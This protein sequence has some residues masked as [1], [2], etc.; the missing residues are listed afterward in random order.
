MAEKPQRLVQF[1]GMDWEKEE[2]KSIRG[3][4]ARKKANFSSLRAA[5]RERTKIAATQRR[6]KVIAFANY[7]CGDIIE[8]DLREEIVAIPLL[9]SLDCICKHVAMKHPMD[10]NPIVPDSLVER[11]R[12]LC[13]VLD[14]VPATNSAFCLFEAWMRHSLRRGIFKHDLVSRTSIE[15]DQDGIEAILAVNTSTE[16]RLPGEIGRSRVSK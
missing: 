3:Y 12:L 8:N 1:Q 2:R 5:E 4:E 16:N 6:A 15:A 13:S 10:P 7:L 14:D 11:L 9:S